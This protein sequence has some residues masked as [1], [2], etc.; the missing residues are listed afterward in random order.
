MQV[1]FADKILLNKLDLV[2]DADKTAV[3][4]RI[5]V[6]HGGTRCGLLS[7]TC[8]AM[9]ARSLHINML[10]QP[11]HVVVVKLL[12]A[13]MTC[14]PSTAAQRS[15]SALTPRWGAAGAVHGDGGDLQASC[16]Q[17]NLRAMLLQVDLGRVLGISAFSLDRMLTQDPQ[18]LVGLAWGSQGGPKAAKSMHVLVFVNTRDALCWLG[19]HE[20]PPTHKATFSAAGRS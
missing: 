14:R 7:R 17:H 20:R 5:R 4:K 6:R 9:H 12:H 15:L 8:L 1:A 18:F 16:T 11:R 13:C 19:L 10:H 3:V 2:T